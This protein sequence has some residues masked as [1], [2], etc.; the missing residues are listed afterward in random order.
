[1]RCRSHG[2]PSAVLAAEPD[3]VLT[4]QG[5]C[6]DGDG[7]LRGGRTVSDQERAC[8]AVAAYLLGTLCSTERASFDRHLDRCASCRA[9]LAALTPLLAFLQGEGSAHRQRGRG[10][11]RSSCFPSATW[12]PTGGPR[13]GAGPCTEDW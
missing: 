13:S 5:A 10:R 8:L 7:L 1:M 4:R 3:A 6:D 11:E 12:S 2:D 9:E